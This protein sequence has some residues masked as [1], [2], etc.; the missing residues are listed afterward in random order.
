MFG[1]NPSLDVLTRAIF[2]LSNKLSMD[3]RSEENS[4]FLNWLGVSA[5]FAILRTFF[6]IK[7]PTVCA[8][9]ETLCDT[10]KD[11]RRSPVARVLFQIQDTVRKNCPMTAD[12]VD[13]LEIAVEIGSGADGMLDIAERASQSSSSSCK[14]SH[15]KRGPYSLALFLLAAAR[16]DIPMMKVLIRAFGDSHDKAQIPY[17]DLEEDIFLVMHQVFAWDP[18]EIK[19]SFT[20]RDYFQLLKEGGILSTSP[21]VSCCYQDRHKLEV[22]NFLSFTIDELVMLCPPV[23]RRKLYCAILRC[24]SEHAG[25]LSRAGIFTAALEGAQNLLDYIHCCKQNNAFD[26][27]VAMQECLVFAAF[28]NDTQTASALVQLGVD[29]EVSLLSANQVPDIYHRGD[30][31]WNPMVIAAAERSLETLELLSETGDLNLFLRTAPFYQICHR[32]GTSLWDPYMNAMSTELCRLQSIRFHLGETRLASIIIDRNGRR[33]P[34][35]IHGDQEICQLES[36]LSR[37]DTWFSEAGTRGIETIT[38]IRAIAAAHGAGAR[39]DKEIIKAALFDDRSLRCTDA[40][41]HPCDVL[42]LDGLVDSNLDY[43]EGGMDLLQLSIRAQCNLDV[44]EFL[45]SKGLRVH[46]RAAAQSGNTMLHDA[47]LGRSR[48]R[49]KIVRLL[50]REGADLKHPGDGLTVLEASLQWDFDP[51]DLEFPSDYL[52]IFAHLLDTGAPVKQKQQPRPKKLKPL[53]DQLVRACAEDDLILRVV[54]AGADL[55]ERGDEHEQETPLVKAIAHGREKLARELIVRGADVHAPADHLGG[56]TA[57]QAAC[58]YCSSFQF[59]EYLVKVQRANVNEAPIEFFGWTALQQAAVTGS[60][61]LV[62]FLLDH[63]ADVNALSG[64]EPEGRRFPEVYRALDFAAV[65]GRLDMVEFL[66]KAGGRSS[67][68]GLGGA[69]VL[70]KNHDHF[71]VVSVLL[72]W[73][74]QHGRRLVEEEV[75]WQRRHPDAARLLSKCRSYDDF[76]DGSDSQVSGEEEP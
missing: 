23:K 7:T 67:T 15:F 4:W 62:E 21:P 69:I 71:A 75:E 13:F 32:D 30:I 43:H 42:L 66:L 57:L 72:D 16:R 9:Y 38:W 5:E 29:P 20:I 52:D 45:L 35:P 34:W 68:R 76:S 64:R 1:G 55:N 40:S 26:V 48:D 24:N 60:M 11:L 61:A 18:E 65:Y 41:Y 50:L 37:T 74:K 12:G 54:D 70:A 22:T 46:S 14:G 31:S 6:S 39:I 19:D 25:F 28:L 33:H 8:A 51:W 73:E 53:I 44:V 2:T 10:A 17:L 56:C 58:R 27:H 63:G 47:L 49:S 36:T 59:V 3:W